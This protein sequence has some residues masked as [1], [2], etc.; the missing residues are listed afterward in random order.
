[1]LLRVRTHQEKVETEYFIF[2]FIGV[3]YGITLFFVGVVCLRCAVGR[4]WTYSCFGLFLLPC[5]RGDGIALQVGYL[6]APL[7]RL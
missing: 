6:W 2:I 4:S 1:M 3:L 7:P 5:T